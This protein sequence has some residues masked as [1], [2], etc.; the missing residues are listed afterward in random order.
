MVGR[1]Q[2]HLLHA[3]LGNLTPHEFAANIESIYL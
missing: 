2:I 1:I 3:S